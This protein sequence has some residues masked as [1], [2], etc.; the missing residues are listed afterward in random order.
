MSDDKPRGPTGPGEP[1]SWLRGASG[2]LSHTE[3]LVTAWGLG[4]TLGPP[5]P[6]RLPTLCETMNFDGSTSSFSA[7]VLRSRCRESRAA[8]CGCRP[9]RT[10]AEGGWPC[11]SRS[12]AAT[13]RASTATST[14]SS[15]GSP[16]GG[17][18]I[19]PTRLTPTAR[20]VGQTTALD[21]CARASTR[22]PRPGA[23]RRED[24]SGLGIP[25]G[26]GAA[27]RNRKR[28]HAHA[29]IAHLDLETIVAHR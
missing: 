3:G 1:P 23:T 24:C 25:D 22:D 17:R 13:R 16:V 10:R 9:R 28:G 12:Y 29:S 18:T 27:P 19:R 8:R 11:Q 7:V 5:D 21:S 6:L 15:A 14:T 20:Q 4:N 26:Y 2:G